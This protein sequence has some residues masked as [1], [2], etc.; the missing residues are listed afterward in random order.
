MKKILLFI[1]LIYVSS[2]YAVM[3]PTNFKTIEQGETLQS[4]INKCGTPTSQSTYIKQSQISG[5]I[6][7]QYSGATGTSNNGVANIYG[8]STGFSAGRVEIVTTQI[9]ELRYN[10]SVLIFENGLLVEMYR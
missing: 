1:L 4:I 9:T 6:G 8:T 7:S 2:S 3:C 10:H 5:Q